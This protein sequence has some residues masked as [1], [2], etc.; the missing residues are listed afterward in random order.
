MHWTEKFV[1]R[2]YS[3]LDCIG[4]V[5]EVGVTQFGH[6]LD[7]PNPN[8][9]PLTVEHIHRIGEG[10]AVAVNEPEDGDAVLMKVIG[11][12]R[13][14]GGHIGVYVAV[15]GEP[16]CLHSLEPRVIFHPIRMLPR[17]GLEKLG[18]YRWIAQ[19]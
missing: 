6:A 10:L 13:S 8:G 16:W 3:D 11:Q 19:W 18:F 7:L 17:L 15:S 1:G 14:L 2:P 12:R 9:K 5:C 4:L